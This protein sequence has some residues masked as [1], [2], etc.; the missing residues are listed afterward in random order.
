M[1]KKY[2]KGTEIVSGKTKD[3]FLAVDSESG[4]PDENLVIVTNRNDITADDNP[5]KTKEFQ[6]KGKFATNT[7]CNIF[8][9]LKKAGIPIAYEERLSD[10]SFIIHKTEMIPLEV[11]IRRYAVGSYTKRMPHLAA[12]N[13][14]NPHRFE[15]LIFEL[16]LKTTEGRCERNGVCIKVGIPV[17]DPLIINPY[18]ELWNLYQPKQPSHEKGANLDIIIDSKDVLKS[19]SVDEIEVLTRKVFLVIEAALKILGLR[20]IDFK[21]EFGITNSGVLVVSDVIDNDSGRL[22]T[23]KWEELSKENHRQGLAIE[24]VSKTYEIVSLLSDRLPIIP[25]Q[26]I[27]F[28]RGSVSD[29][30]P[31]IPNIYGIAEE[32]VTIS[33][34]KQPAKVLEKLSELEA[35]YPQGVVI[36][37]IAGMSNGLGPILS[38]Q[39]SWPV[40][41]CPPELIENPNDIWSSI[42]LPSNVPASTIVNPKNAVLNA[43]NILALSN[44]IA[45]MLRRYEIEKIVNS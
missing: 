43:L 27:V 28:W 16:F 39:T 34:H 19:V 31:T 25:E 8:E 20:Y 7:T 30:H 12:K 3:I 1:S 42:N 9:L 21:I 23:A 36:I 37:A 10:E 38:A 6:G 32:V 5:D 44:P 15:N 45:G 4:R 24:E 35:K 18:D 41:N 14:E 29:N 11:I 33:A 22:R 40:I 13:G 17:E 2:I 26:A